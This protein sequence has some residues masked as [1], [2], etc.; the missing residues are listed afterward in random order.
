MWHQRQDRT[1]LAVRLVLAALLATGPRPSGATLVSTVDSR[2]EVAPADL[3]YCVSEVNRYR[4]LVGAPPLSQS[5]VAEQSAAEAAPVDHRGRR[6]HQHF[7]RARR[8][9][10]EVEARRWPRSIAS[11]PRSFAFQALGQM[12]AEGPGGGHFE[13]MRSLRYTTTGCG[14]SGDSKFATFVQHFR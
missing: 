3:A 5:A 2:F 9:Y 6:A 7:R 1:L 13:I 8:D 14:F 11:E 12:W 4:A 10:A